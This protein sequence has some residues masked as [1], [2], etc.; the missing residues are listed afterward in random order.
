MKGNNTLNTKMKLLITL[1]SLRTG[2]MQQY[3]SD[4]L[5]MSQHT[6]K[7][8]ITETVMPAE[9]SWANNRKLSSVQLA[10]SLGRNWQ[11]RRCHPARGC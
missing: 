2:K 7:R 5:G 8:V 11:S 4:D 9:P 10:L 1:R 3:S 6:V